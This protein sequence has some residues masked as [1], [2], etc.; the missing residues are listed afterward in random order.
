MNS[1][2]INEPKK[3]KEQ[4]IAARDA[5]LAQY[6][7]IRAPDKFK[8]VPNVPTVQPKTGSDTLKGAPLPIV[9]PLA[10]PRNIY[11]NRR[12][13]TNLDA[14]P[15]PEPQTQQATLNTP[16]SSTSLLDDFYPTAPAEDDVRPADTRMV[17]RDTP[18]ID[19]SARSF[20]PP[21]SFNSRISDPQSSQSYDNAMSVYQAP[22]RISRANQISDSNERAMQYEINKQIIENNIDDILQDLEGITNDYGDAI[23]IHTL[24]SQ[25]KSFANELQAFRTKHGSTDTQ[26]IIN[27]NTLAYQNKMANFDPFVSSDKNA[28]NNLANIQEMKALAEVD[29]PESTRTYAEA[30]VDVFRTAAQKSFDAITNPYA[31]MG[32][33][34]LAPYPI[35]AAVQYFGA[36][37]RTSLIYN[38]QKLLTFGFQLVDDIRQDS[39]QETADAETAK[40]EAFKD[41][42]KNDKME[43]E[44]P[45]RFYK[46][47]EQAPSLVIS[48]DTKKDML[49]G[50][51]YK[52]KASK[53]AYI[54]TAITNLLR[55]SERDRDIDDALDTHM[56]YQEAKILQA[57]PN[58]ATAKKI[59]GEKNPNNQRLAINY[60]TG[61]FINKIKMSGAQIFASSDGATRIGEMSREE[62]EEEINNIITSVE[63]AFNIPISHAMGT[64]DA[65]NVQYDK[66]QYIKNMAF[67]TMSVVAQTVVSRA[68]RTPL[69]G[70]PQATAAD[71]QSTLN[72]YLQ[73]LKQVATWF[74]NNQNA[75]RDTAQLLGMVVGWV[76][77][78]YGINLDTSFSQQKMPGETLL[79]KTIGTIVGRG[80]GDH[81]QLKDVLLQYKTYLN[82]NMPKQ[83]KSTIITKI[84]DHFDTLPEYKTGG[85]MKKDTRGCGVCG[86]KNDL[87][88]HA[89]DAD[90][91]TCNSCLTRNS[92]TGGRFTKREVD[93][94]PEDRSTNTSHISNSKQNKINKYLDDLES[95]TPSTMMEEFDRSAPIDKRFLTRMSQD[96]IINRPYDSPRFDSKDLDRLTYLLG[97]SEHA[98]E[99]MTTSQR[100]NMEALSINHLERNGDPKAAFPNFNKLDTFSNIKEQLTTN[101]GIL[102]RLIS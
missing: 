47:D 39:A 40:A 82:N 97:L 45:T 38:L 18:R 91:I 12:Q 78:Q 70:G 98:P 66:Q 35:N 52:E 1:H 76:F 10:I 58:S 46:S 11:N 56:E 8:T 22:D 55:G 20:N 31:L 48:A 74:I 60:E 100:V 93:I 83:T 67:S 81:R 73:T 68:Q 30:T 63:E 13:D 96:F 15:N 16:S 85:L 92:M 72:L 17:L 65:Q 59:E 101:P 25:N 5:W 99:T 42:W 6:Q 49:Q 21:W 95:T 32:A 64:N 61:Q 36:L 3:T 14:A 19:Y 2:Y 24:A 54:N 44:P 27:N 71:S 69:V 28:A 53:L 23:N 84:L 89:M 102:K 80:I 87:M 51:Y 62:Y 7:K 26:A 75:I 86:G 94:I 33:S 29:G 57:E 41:F 79:K 90:D 88:V 4:L 34:I 77:R 43:V 9:P 37:P 50:S